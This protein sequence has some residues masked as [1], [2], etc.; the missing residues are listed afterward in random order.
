LAASNADDEDTK[1]AEEVALMSEV[2]KVGVEEHES[3]STLSRR[4][5]MEISR[6]QAL[7]SQV[8]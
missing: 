2:A 1:A 3:E 8:H 4:A 6:R 5:K 7:L